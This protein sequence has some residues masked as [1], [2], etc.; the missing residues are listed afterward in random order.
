MMARL[1]DI[2]KNSNLS[3]STLDKRTAIFRMETLH[4]AS[5]LTHWYPISM[6]LWESLIGPRH[7]GA[8]AC[9]LLLNQLGK[10]DGGLVMNV[11]DTFRGT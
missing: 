1:F 3:Q 11:R 9:S 7:I 10:R 2:R 6:D 5:V 8:L 4:M